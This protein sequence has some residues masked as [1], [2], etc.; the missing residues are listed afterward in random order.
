[1]ITVGIVGCGKIADDHVALVRAIPDCEVVGVVDREELMAMQLADRFKIGAYF[2]DVRSLLDQVKPQVVHVTTPPQGHFEIARLC[3]QAGAH[4][5]VEKPFTVN[6]R[7]A[8][9]LVDLARRTNRKITVHH[10]QQFT[11]PARR[12]RKLIDE[13]FLGGPP[14]HM[15]SYY[16]YE[17]GQDAYAKSLL[18]DR[19]HWVR[20][21]PGQL[22]H[23]VISHGIS[24]IAEYIPTDSP[25]VIAHGFASPFVRRIGEEGIIDELRVI[26]SDGDHFT[27]YF[28]FSSQMRPNLHLLRVYGSKNGVE[29][30]HD[31]RTLTTIKGA[32]Q[33]SILEKIV[34][35]A[36]YAM[37]HA[38]NARGNV[39]RLLRRELHPRDGSLFLFDRFYRS[40]R[41]DAPV[42]VSDREM[43]LTVSIMDEIF[44]QI[45]AA[46][47][48]ALVQA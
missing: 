27:A 33:K 15:E 16:G 28:T 22:L 45:G 32:R 21:L 39:G 44:A 36:S 14:I 37:Q 24:K 31:Q 9:E 46:K 30:D 10:E 4:T 26:I 40:V 19:N 12:A 18:G 29:I 34:S 41:D 1:M 20:R 25:T 38:R 47:P 3:L 8:R 6:A 11:D 17:L 35:P 43:V 5:V 13:G 2:T 23:N 7:E 48:S 42:P